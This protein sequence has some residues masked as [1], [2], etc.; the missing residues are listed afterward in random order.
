[1]CF[2]RNFLSFTSIFEFEIWISSK[3]EWIL[4]KRGVAVP[5][6]SRH[7]AHE[8][9]YICRPL[10]K[11]PHLSRRSLKHIRIWELH[12]AYV[13]WTIAISNSQARQWQAHWTIHVFESSRGPKTTI[14]WFNWYVYSYLLIT[15]DTLWRSLVTTP[16]CR[17]ILISKYPWNWEEKKSTFMA[18]HYHHHDHASSS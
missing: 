16:H 5:D 17:I 13:Q 1:M 15:K 18:Q 9:N 6:G 4:K 14:M 2:K 7:T 11:L 12:I 3:D 8:L 10:P